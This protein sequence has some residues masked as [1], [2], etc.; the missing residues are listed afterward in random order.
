MAPRDPVAPATPAAPEIPPKGSIDAIAE[1]GRHA[2]GVTVLHI[3]TNGLG[4]GLPPTVP[5]LFDHR[6]GGGLKSIRDE[7]DK[8]RLDPE[9]CTGT[10]RATTR[11]SFIKLVLRHQLPQ[12]ALFAKTEWPNPQ[13]LAVIDYHAMDAGPGHLRHR[14]VYDFPVSDEFKAW[15]GND[16]KPMTQQQFAEFCEERVCDLAA[17]TVQ[18]EDLYS[19]MFRV[20]VASPADMVTL[21]RGLQVNVEAVA[22]STVTLHSGEGEIIFAEQHLDNSRQKLVVPGLFMICAPAFVGGD[23]VRLPARLRYRVA[24]GK[25]SWQYHLFQWRLWI[26]QRVIDDL[27]AVAEATGLPAY[28]GAPEA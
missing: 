17:P 24:N 18:E 14:V 3:P 5:L 15:S 22:K 26:R 16:A 10:A 4:E 20:P 27:A 21:S 19:S 12:S 2:A 11:D 25:V 28:E 23:P 9:R 13:L 7:I 1:L 6:N 8:Y